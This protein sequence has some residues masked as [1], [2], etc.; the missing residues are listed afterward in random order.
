[1]VKKNFK[2]Q[3]IPRIFTPPGP[4]DPVG[5][6]LAEAGNIGADKLLRTIS[7]FLE[8]LTSGKTSPSPEEQYRRDSYSISL[9]KQ[10]IELA[11]AQTQQLKAAEQLKL[12]EH[13]V[14]EKEL[15]LEKSRQQLPG[16]SIQ[17]TEMDLHVKTEV[18]T[19][20]LELAAN[21]GGLV[22]SDE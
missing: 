19:G 8:K 4:H 22:V 2:S 5:N 9:Q 14:A 7:S 16:V 18:I 20:A 21:S 17:R 6:F 10:Q 11:K 13:K 1:M 12:T 3:R 15:Q